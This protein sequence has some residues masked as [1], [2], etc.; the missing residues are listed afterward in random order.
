MEEGGEKRRTHAR[1]K[2]RSGALQRK[3]DGRGKVIEFSCAP[4]LH[5]IIVFLINLRFMLG[6][7]PP[8]TKHQRPQQKQTHPNCNPT[9]ITKQAPKLGF[10]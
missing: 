1:K 8:R 9:K 6:T 4:N 7:P 3:G 10:F 5:I 2:D